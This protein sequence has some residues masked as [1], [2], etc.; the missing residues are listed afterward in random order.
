MVTDEDFEILGPAQVRA[1]L[2][3]KVYLGAEEALAKAWLAR[4]DEASQARQATDATRAA[5]AAEFAA[6][7]AAL[8]K[9]WQQPPTGSRSPLL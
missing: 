5:D 2:V 4:R 9:K 8:A 7:E 3:T 6:R 1:H